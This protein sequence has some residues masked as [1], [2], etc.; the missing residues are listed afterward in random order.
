MKTTS[1]PAHFDIINLC[2]SQF[3][4]STIHATDTTLS[5]MLQRYLMQKAISRFEFGGL[6]EKWSRTYFLYSLF[7]YGSIAIFDHKEKFGIIPQ[8]FTFTGFDVFY[9]PTEAVISNALLQGYENL[10]IDYGGYTGSI[11]PA[12]AMPEKTCAILRLTP[13]WGGIF[14]SVVYYADL[15][16]T[17]MEA[18]AVN[19]YNSKLAYVFM[20]KNKTAAESFKK[21]FDQIQEGNPAV[22]LDKNLFTADGD[23]AWLQ[24]NQD[25]R[26]TYLA[27]DILEDVKKI[28]SQFNTLIGIPNVNIAKAS[29]VSEGEVNAN[30]VDTFS[31][32]TLWLETMQEDLKLIN[33]KFGL[34]ITVKFSDLGGADNDIINPGTD[35]GEA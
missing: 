28:E 16:A 27:G 15:M 24:F 9:R 11:L 25:L 8:H 35:P 17:A 29:G 20:S 34:N 4:P 26:T 23:P 12:E 1:I 14:D 2:N 30:N 18:A 31:R 6:P 13:D 22:F 3:S 33:R 7:G 5:A 21:M 10:A 19:L 32:A